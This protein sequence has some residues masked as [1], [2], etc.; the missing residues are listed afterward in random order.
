MSTEAAA[1]PAATP[2]T[3]EIP[4]LS[5]EALVD[6]GVHF[7][8]STRFWDPRMKRMI[9]GK[10]NG[11]HIINLRETL[12]GAVR[13]RYFLK[14]IASA[15]LDILIVGTK[16]QAE[17]VVRSEAN[18]I[19][20]PFVSTR[21][22]GGT[23]TNFSTIRARLKRLQEIE[24]LK[25]TGKFDSLK[26]KQQ[27]VVDR[28]HRKI[29]TNLE[30]LRNLERLPSAVIVVDA[31]YEKNAIQEAR[32]L[33]IPVIALVDTDS[34]PDVVDIAIPANDDSLRG[35]QILL[36]Y[37]CDGIAEGNEE[38]TRGVGLADKSGLIISGYDDMG[39]SRREQRRDEQRGGRGGPGGGGGRGR[40]G[41]GG[42]GGGGGGGYGGPRG[43][44]PERTEQTEAA[45]EAGAEEAVRV[46]ESQNVR[47]RAAVKVKGSPTKPADAAPAAE[48]APAAPAAPAPKP[49]EAAPAADKPA[50]SGSEG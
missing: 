26:K 19:G 6:A 44:A 40:G 37:I 48:A 17:D 36:R 34:N 38:H 41:Q 35:I 3:I 33:N 14:Q 11:I 23:L 20:A 10:K 39:P 8:H 22:L 15:G 32:K 27:S 30:G 28:E 1:A 16:K 25:S 5:A 46:A 2:A 9:F 4:A 42:G 21:W 45:V 24:T 18:R 29:A 43:R 31:R 49:A 47:E 12:R 7:G 13:A 50:D